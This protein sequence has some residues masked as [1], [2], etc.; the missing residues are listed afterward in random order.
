MWVRIRNIF[1]GRKS[2]EFF[3]FLFFFAVSSCFWLLQTLNETFETE[4][5]VPLELKNIPENVH[6]TTNL[7]SQIHITIRDR[8]TTLLRFFRYTVQNAIEV[9]F[10]KY[11]AGFTNARVQVPVADV[12]RMIQSQLGVSSH[13]ISVRPDTLEYYYNRGV[14]RKLPVKVCGSISASPQNYIQSLNLSEDSIL[15]YAPN[16]VLDTMQYAYTQVVSLSDLKENTVQN[17][18]FRRMKGVEYVPNKVEMTASVGYYAEKTVE[19]PIIGLNF[20]GDKELRT[21]PSRAKV[22]FRVESGQ[23]QRITADNFVLAITYEELL[24]NPSDKYR[25]HLKSLPEGVTNARI[26]PLE[27]DYLIEKS[28]MDGESR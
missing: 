8:G 13:I 21:F 23:Y 28:E 6:I 11:D 3:V 5:S 2:H 12:Q 17:I 19:V 10:E 4:I 16:S 20:P 9:D 24:Q 26:S 1:F 27:V 22:T 7:P 14:A 15:V 18:S 25:L